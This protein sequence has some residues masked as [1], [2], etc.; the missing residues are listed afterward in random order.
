MCGECRLCRGRE[1]DRERYRRDR[2]KRLRQAHETYVRARKAENPEWQPRVKMTPEERRAKR[3]EG[4][5]RWRE[6]KR[7][8]QKEHARKCYL[9]KR[10][11]YNEQSRARYRENRDAALAYNKR[12][13]EENPEPSRRA[14]RR[15]KARKRNQPFTPLA[16][17]WMGVI[18]RD[19]CSYCGAPMQ[20][21]DHIIALNAGGDGDWDN[22]A[23][24]C[25][26]CNESKQDTPL[27]AWM[28][29]RRRDRG[30]GIA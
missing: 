6:A 17:L 5:R 9:A 24:A 12:W 26:S 25:A 30:R 11:E 2:E 23:A 18:E 27:L 10:D 4:K 3:L 16:E 21:V 14:K 20:H 8:R 13:R 19:P 28:A 22:L 29:T 1:R 7:E 15:Y